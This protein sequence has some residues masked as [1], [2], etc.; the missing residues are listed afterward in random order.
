MAVF[1]LED[2]QGGVE[3]IVFPEAYQRARGADRNRHAGAGARQARARRRVGAD[4]GVGDRAA[5]QRA[6]A[7][8]ARGRDPPHGSR[9]TAACSR[10]SARSSRAIA[11]TGGC[12]SR[13]STGERR[14]GCACAPTSSSQIRVR[15][16]AGADRGSRADRRARARCRCDDEHEIACPRPRDGCIDMPPET[17]EFEEPI[18]VAAEG[19]RG[20]RRCCRAPTRASA[21]SSR[22]GAASSR[23]ARELYASL[24]PW[25]RVLVA[26]HPE[27]SGPRGLHPAAVHRTSSRSTATGAS[28]TTTRS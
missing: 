19:D 11:A 22:C 3:V 21:R 27:P 13:S 18:A 28:P 14:R 2:A 20:A 15:P 5:R 1:T 16:V 4:P 6:R 9:P 17:L 24:T 7:A 26:R 23:S 10:R 12:R 8:G 25:Q